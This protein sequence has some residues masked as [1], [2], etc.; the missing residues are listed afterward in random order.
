MASTDSKTLYSIN[1]ADRF[2]NSAGEDKTKFREVAV[3]FSN[4]KGG[5]S[6]QLPK[7][8]TLTADAE[9]VIFPIDTKDGD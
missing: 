2:T 8:L 7:G 4:R 5:L 3:G 1:V 9:V 6:F